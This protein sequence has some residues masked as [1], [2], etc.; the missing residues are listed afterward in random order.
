MRCVVL[1]AGLVAG[2]LLGGAEA[3]S[4]F[5]A[6]LYRGVLHLPAQTVAAGKLSILL[7]DF[8]CRGT[9]AEKVHATRIDPSHSSAGLPALHGVSFNVAGMSVA[10]C[11]GNY[12][13]TFGTSKLAKGA[14]NFSVADTDI[15]IGAFQRNLAER[16]FDF[17]GRSMRGLDSRQRNSFL[18]EPCRYPE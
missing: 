8:E 15:T 6:W 9:G 5:A 17:P 13:T 10:L 18:G 3:E 12:S 16:A 4:D 1:V 14:F 7:S 2:A 11:E